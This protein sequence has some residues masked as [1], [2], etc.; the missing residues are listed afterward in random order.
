MIFFP[1]CPALNYR[2][3]FTKTRPTLRFQLP[4]SSSIAV[5]CF[6]R[7]WRRQKTEAEGGCSGEP[8]CCCCCTGKAALAAL[9]E[10][11]SA[12]VRLFSADAFPCCSRPRL[13][14]VKLNSP[15]RRR[16]SRTGQPLADIAGC[17]IQANRLIEQIEGSSSHQDFT[18]LKTLSWGKD[19]MVASD[20]WCATLK[21][22]TKSQIDLKTKR[23]AFTLSSR[24]AGKWHRNDLNAKPAL[25]T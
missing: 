22:P 21:L 10:C 8:V 12:T 5:C 23:F 11:K 16:T 6:E 14:S 2:E 18:S 4:H 24:S 1:Y 25:P 17:S 13:A 3:R 20:H 9:S 15:A 19:Q 7:P